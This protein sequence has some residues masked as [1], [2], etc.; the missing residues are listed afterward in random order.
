MRFRINHAAV[1]AQANAIAQLSEDL[2]LQI[3]QLNTME[4]NLRAG[5]S[6]PAA[7][8]YFASVVEL[9]NQIASQRTQITALA[10]VIR[11][12][13]NAIQRADEAAARRLAEI[14]F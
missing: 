13:A 11:N 2:Q 8:A 10:N 12:S 7:T 9:R 6:G 1:I 14:R 3:N 5:W 4:Q